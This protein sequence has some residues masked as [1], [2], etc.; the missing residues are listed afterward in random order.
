MLR[1]LGINALLLLPGA[2]ILYFG[3]N[4]G[5]FYPGSVGVAG[6]VLCV[7]LVLRIGLAERPFAGL[8]WSGMA[9]AGALV[10]FAA[11]TL[12][13][14]LWS[15]AAAR[16][17]F[18]FDRALVYALAF[19]LLGSLPWT[20]RRARVAVTGLAL[21]F[22]V[23]AGAGFL[24]RVAP[25]LVSSGPGVLT[26]RLSYPLTY[27][28]SDGLACALGIMLCVHLSSAPGPRLPRVVACVPIP[29]F[30][31][32]LL[33]TFSRGAIGALVLGL[34]VYIIAARER[35]TAFTALAVTPGAF[36]AVR[37]AYHANL[38]GRPEFTTAAAQ[39]QGHDL[40]ITVV[41][42]CAIAL[43]L[44]ALLIL[45]E[46]RLAAR[47]RLDGRPRVAGAL[48]AAVVATVIVGL[49]LVGAPARIA[50]GWNRFKESPPAAA[51]QRDRLTQV[52]NNGRIAHWH[53]ARDGFR[54]QPLHG[55]GAGTYQVMWAQQRPVNATVN[56]AHSLPLEVAG[57]LGIVGVVLLGIALLGIL[58][59]SMW[60]AR[61]PD[62]AAAAV[63][64]A[65]GAAWLGRA[66]IDWD[67]E[68]PSVTLWF[69][70][71]GGLS[72][73]R[74]HGTPG[75]APPPLARVVGMLIV[76]ALAVLPIQAALSQ[77]RLNGA[78]RAFHA[79]DCTKAID[80]S[81]AASSALPARPEP[82]QILAFCD[83]RLGRGELAAEVARKAM[84][85]DPHNWEFPYSLA[86]VQA[87]AGR[88]PRAAA[89]RALRLNPKEPLT[90]DAVRRFKTSDKR[91]WERRARTAPL[92]FQ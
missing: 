26:G 1:W 44:R 25:D 9:V 66:S 23:I 19:L 28:N 12:A 59:G 16:A 64:V 41:V 24:S 72:L 82:F 75:A 79:G 81:L 49:L 76:L 91:L 36:L 87:A 69:F 33:L 47:G 2:L 54:R 88:D 30:G 58:V 14:S 45:A 32:T 62:R 37:A 90:R 3:F 61:G 42:G 48:A 92:P 6:G 63:M 57:E 35:G 46:E 27:W 7:A 8:R 38:L 85:R 34:V 43:V 84:A 22:L 53:V 13:S 55:T 56:D 40:A 31:A 78:V 73:A 71:L 50:D 89:A 74:R 18:E 86:V 67:W 65:A 77:H 51:Q 68:M 29:L 70:A 11:W 20:A 15:G 4:A 60:R 21:S 80:R 10:G 17:I 39:A 52:S 83:A 5:G